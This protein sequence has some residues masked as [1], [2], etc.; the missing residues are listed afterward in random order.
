ME[1][2]LVIKRIGQFGKFQARMVFLV[3]GIASFVTSLQVLSI[4]FLVPEV[5]FRCVRGM[6]EKVSAMPR[7]WNWNETLSLARS[8]TK[9]GS[10]ETDHCQIMVNDKSEECVEW[11]YETSGT[12]VQE[13]DLVCSRDIFRSTLTS[14]GM[15]GMIIGVLA[16]GILSDMFGRKKTFI[17]AAIMLAL[18]GCVSAAANS[19]YLLIAL[20]FCTLGSQV[21]LFTTAFVYCMELIGGK[22]NVFVGIGLELPWAVGYMVL[23][24]FAY[25]I[26]YWANLQ[27]AISIP[28][29]LF[30][31]MLVVPG[32]VPESPK[33]LLTKGR[34]EEAREIIEKIEKINGRTQS[35]GDNTLTAP[36][37][38]N[39]VEG[40]DLK[41]L[42]NSPHTIT[43]TLVMFYLWFCNSLVYYG[44]VLNAGSLLPGNLY[45][46]YLVS[47]FLEVLAY[48]L[49]IVVY[50]YGGRRVPQ[51]ITMGLAGLCLLFTLST[52]NQTVVL[53]LSQVG[54]FMIT[55]SFAMVYLYA[56]EIF[57]TVLRNVG[58]G[59]S[60]FNARIG[61]ILAPFAGRELKMVDPSAPI[62]LFGI[63]SVLAGILTLVLPETRDT[64]LPDSIKEGEKKMSADP[65]FFRSCLK[66]NQYN[67]SS[68]TD[69]G[70]M[71]GGYN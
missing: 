20:R 43:C 9:E 46:N 40:L 10:N 30:A 16:S 47:G 37:T 59:T 29:L 23:P 2:D 50:Y 44:L 51:A 48:L 66:S 58:L 17:G 12:V 21:A 55:G 71:N 41:E 8:P 63:C 62:L 64:K 34:V 60:S 7:E 53:V 68:G 33:W 70:K 26:P 22:W 45:I 11:I 57:P 61:S 19:I 56:A 42:L 28:S 39:E 13:F 3:G 38:K 54:K 1:D 6:S 25:I 14:V 31:V 35:D 4:G 65:G 24:G 15:A 5:E 69:A 18:F 32:L 27:I 52:T 67:V 36:V 49:T